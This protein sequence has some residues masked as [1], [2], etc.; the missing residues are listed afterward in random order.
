GT[1]GDFVDL[2]NDID[3]QSGAVV[4]GGTAATSAAAL[5]AERTSGTQL[6]TYRTAVAA[7]GEYTAFFGGTV[8]AGQAAIVTSVNRVSGIYETELAIRLTL[9]ANNSS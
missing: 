1:P 4:S 8:S 6:R 5:E 2:S 7:T 3:L 9:V